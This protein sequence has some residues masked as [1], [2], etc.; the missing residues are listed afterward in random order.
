L[1]CSGSVDGYVGDDC[2]GEGSSGVDS[3]EQPTSAD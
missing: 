1:W 3:G 2:D